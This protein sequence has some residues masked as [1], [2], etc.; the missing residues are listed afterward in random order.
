M[1][2][3]VTSPLASVTDMQ[4]QKTDETE[5]QGYCSSETPTYIFMQIRPGG[6]SFPSTPGLP[7]A[8]PKSKLVRRVIGC[9]RLPEKRP[10]SSVILS[11]PVSHSKTL[12]LCP[13]CCCPED[14][15]LF[16]IPE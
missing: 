16:L 9:S 7:L 15:T 3:D 5:P 13:F 12:L 10:W 8:S 6:F 1:W 11:C 14:F 2:Q 4:K